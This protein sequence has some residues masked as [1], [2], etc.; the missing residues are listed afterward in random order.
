MLFLLCKEL[1]NYWDTRITSLL[2]CFILPKSFKYPQNIKLKSCGPNFTMHKNYIYIFFASY[3][4][5]VVSRL[6]TNHINGY[7]ISTY[8]L[9]KFVSGSNMVSP[10]TR[11]RLLLRRSVVRLVRPVNTPDSRVARLLEKRNNFSSWPH[12]L[13]VPS[14]MCC[15]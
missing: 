7:H 5:W 2:M 6:L 11:R 13:K 12:S 15:K 4:L 10:M 1:K 8:S 14:G 3:I 9:V